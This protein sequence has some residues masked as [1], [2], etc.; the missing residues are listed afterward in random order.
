MGAKIMVDDK[1]KYNIKAI[2]QVVGIQPGTLRAWERRYHI[3]EPIRNESGHRLYTDEHVAILRWLIDKVNR[4]FTIGQAVCVLEKNNL[5]LETLRNTQD[6]HQLQTFIY[7]LKHNLLSFQEAKA[8][9]ILDEVFSVFTVEKVIYEIIWPIIN[10]IE[11][12][13]EKNEITIAHVHFVSQ[14][15]KTRI[16]MIVYRLPLDPLLP[17][18]IAVCGPSERHELSLLLFTIYLRRKGFEVLYFGA[19]IPL[20]DLKLVIQELNSAY[21]V[22]S[23]TMTSTLGQTLSM[24]NELHKSEPNINIGLL[25]EAVNKLSK[26]KKEDFGQYIVGYTID[27]WEKWLKERLFRV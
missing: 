9:Q 4:G 26:R 15:V 18:V 12:A 24:I 20:H 3:I 23:C 14:F 17:K 5:N 7:N 19:N 1:A 2:S 10:E 22:L 16:G 25:G 21:L 27:D 13:W 11:V 8:N 6:N